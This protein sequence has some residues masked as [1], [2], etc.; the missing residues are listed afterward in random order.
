[1][2]PAAFIVF[3]QELKAENPAKQNLFARFDRMIRATETLW[4]RVKW[5]VN[6]DKKTIYEQSITKSRN[7]SG[8]F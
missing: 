1:M 6:N 5:S 8:E 7:T 4:D 3:I 2:T